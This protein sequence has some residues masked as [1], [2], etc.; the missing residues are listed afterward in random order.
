MQAASY[1]IVPVNVQDV[2]PLALCPDTVDR[3]H[4]NGAVRRLRIWFVETLICHVLT[5]KGI[6]LFN[7]D[8]YAPP[9]SS[10]F[11]P[12]AQHLEMAAELLAEILAPSGTSNTAYVGFGAYTQFLATSCASSSN[13]FPAKVSCCCCFAEF[14]NTCSAV[15]I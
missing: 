5:V 14:H 10:R 8:C 9:M 13:S 6:S 11:G 3:E 15:P 12:D 1:F 7:D 4:W 2:A